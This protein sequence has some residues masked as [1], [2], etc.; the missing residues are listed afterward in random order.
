MTEFPGRRLFEVALVVPLAFPAYVMAY[1]YTHLLDHP[2]IVQSTLRDVTGWGPRD[3][4]FPEI[5]SVAGAA[6]MLILVLYPYVYLL[7]R[8]SFRQQSSNAFLVARTLGRSPASAFLRVALPMARPVTV[9]RTVA[10]YTLY[11]P[12]GMAGDAEQ[13]RCDWIDTSFVHED[14]ALSMR[15]DGD[16]LLIQVEQHGAACHEGYKSCFFRKIDP[17][18]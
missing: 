13:L 4:W 3:Y 1:A 14:I 16:T 6:V 15:G 2:G 10:A 9:D 7:A 8:A 18:I 12:A 11:G 17:F 5:R